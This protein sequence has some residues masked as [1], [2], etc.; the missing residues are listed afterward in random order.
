MNMPQIFETKCIVNFRNIEVEKRYWFGVVKIAKSNKIEK[1]EKMIAGYQEAECVVS[2]VQR[3][4]LKANCLN[5]PKKKV[6][7][8][9][10][11]KILLPFSTLMLGK[12]FCK[13]PLRG[14]V[15]NGVLKI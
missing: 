8:V 14:F 5:K 13:P 12:P 1:T 6:S 3:Q 15:E 2:I 7:Y 4:K 10:K 9:S 11:K